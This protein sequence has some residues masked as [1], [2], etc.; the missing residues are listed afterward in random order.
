MAVTALVL[1]VLSFIFAI[2]TGLPAF[3]LGIIAL[4]N[5]EKSGGKL[6][7]KG[8][9]IAGIITPI[10]SLPIILFI[11][12]TNIR[13]LAYRQAC[14]N[15]LATIGKAMLSYAGDN[16]NHLPRAGTEWNPN[17]VI[18]N[19][20]TRQKAFK[21]ENASITSSLY[22]LVKYYGIAPKKFICTGDSGTTEFNPSN[23]NDNNDIKQFWDFGPNGRDHCSYSY[24][25]PYSSL[26]LLSSSDPR[27]A[28]AADPNPW[29]DKNPRIKETSNLSKSAQEKN[30]LNLE[31]Q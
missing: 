4:V 8:F 19:A 15:N 3:V 26:A 9:A 18:W 17:D 7:G 31:M 20:P 1:G 13:Y 28:L 30:L 11:A 14:E 22:L 5:I 25:Q 21:Y 2:F 23:Y 27:M 12:F 10:I 6:T 29:L 16:N 24:Q